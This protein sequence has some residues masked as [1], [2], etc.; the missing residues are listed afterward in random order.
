MTPTLILMRNRV[1]NLC[2]KFHQPPKSET[3][4][5]V[6]MDLCS[7]LDSELIDSEEPTQYFPKFIDQH[8]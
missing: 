4:V 8:V 2:S 1:T 6:Q 3:T 5:L 7:L